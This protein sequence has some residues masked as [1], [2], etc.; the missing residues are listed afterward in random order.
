MSEDIRKKYIR[1]TEIEKQVLIDDFEFYLKQINEFPN[2]PNPLFELLSSDVSEIR[3]SLLLGQN[4]LEKTLEKLKQAEKQTSSKNINTFIF[5][6]NISQNNQLFSFEKIELSELDDY[7][8]YISANLKNL[9][10][11]KLSFLYYD[12]YNKLRLEIT[13]KFDEFFTAENYSFLEELKETLL[14]L[15]YSSFKDFL[16][17]VFQLE[18][19]FNINELINEFD[20]PEEISK[21]KLALH[22]FDDNNFDLDDE[23]Y[24]N[25][26]IHKYVNPRIENIIESLNTIIKDIVEELKEIES[27]ELEINQSPFDSYFVF[28]ININRFRKAGDWFLEDLL[29]KKSNNNLDSSKAQKNR[30]NEES[31]NG[32]SIEGLLEENNNVGPFIN[33]Y[34][35]IIESGSE[36][37]NR[38][39]SSFE[40]YLDIEMRRYYLKQLEKNLLEAVKSDLIYYI[41]HFNSFIGIK[42]FPN[43]I[44]NDLVRNEEISK[45]DNFKSIIL[46][47]NILVKR[48]KNLLNH[49]LIRNWFNNYILKY[50]Y[51]DPSIALINSF[52][53]LSEEIEFPEISG[54]EDLEFWD[55]LRELLDID[56]IIQNCTIHND[57]IERI[58]KNYKESEDIYNFDIISKRII[59]DASIMDKFQQIVNSRINA[60]FESSE[61]SNDIK[62]VIEAI[63]TGKN[64]SYNSSNIESAINTLISNKIIKEIR[65]FVIGF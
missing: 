58:Y 45:E 36:L 20:D 56:E 12:L 24:Y 46:K 42:N 62:L 10:V 6:R 34:N 39:I 27:N 33:M 47:L 17:I 54:S 59:S 41:Q 55:Q 9:I 50:H 29:K 35:W 52:L 64:I 8:K 21:F 38:E 25:I 48:F 19:D 3:L 57:Y 30:D 49:S 32:E 15:D 5:L 13:Q 2:F 44:P 7:Q 65:S 51:I 28:A 37:Q 61:Q 16:S 53:F 43:R 63:V 1:L 14:D 40:H 18:E 31:N 11:I 23:N 26:L 22:N 60:L 4:V